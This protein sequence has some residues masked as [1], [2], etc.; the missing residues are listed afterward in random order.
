MCG[1]EKPEQSLNPKVIY[2][3]LYGESIKNAPKC[4]NKLN[5]ETGFSQNACEIFIRYKSNCLY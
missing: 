3:E 2:L 1:I 4:K 5:V